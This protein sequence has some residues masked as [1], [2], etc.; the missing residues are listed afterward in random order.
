MPSV[1][2]ETFGCQMNVADSDLLFASLACR[3]F[4]KTDNSANADLIVIN[5]CSVREHAETRALA[6]ITQNGANKRH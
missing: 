3:G 2:F 1:F 4:E 6:N 5:T